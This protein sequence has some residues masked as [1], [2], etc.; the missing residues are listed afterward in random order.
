[1][2][3]RLQRGQVVMMFA[4]M[5]P[6]FVIFLAFLIDI[7]QLYYEKSNVQRAADSVIR[8]VEQILGKDGARGER[9][10]KEDIPSSVTPYSTYADLK[11]DYSGAATELEQLEEN[12]NVLASTLN[13]IDI[14]QKFMVDDDKNL[15]YRVDVSNTYNAV[16]KIA[17]ADDGSSST[18]AATVTATIIIK[19]ASD[20]NIVT[21]SVET[22]DPAVKKKNSHAVEYRD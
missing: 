1:M 4:V 16:M 6:I 11:K 7:G 10:E 12:I 14:E 2:I 22:G 13:G 15:Y 19:F 20:K 18:D 21:G 9:I 3:K 5:V 17:S 8:T